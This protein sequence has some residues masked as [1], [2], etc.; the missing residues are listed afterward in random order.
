MNQ[1]QSYYALVFWF[2]WILKCRT[3]YF[4]VYLVSLSGGD[5][6]DELLEEVLE[7]VLSDLFGD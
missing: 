1:N 2:P 5:D 7:A 6:M 4:A 3:I